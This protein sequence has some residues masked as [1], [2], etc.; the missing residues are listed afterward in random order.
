MA[1]TVHQV[2]LAQTQGG[3][4]SEGSLYARAVRHALA[5]PPGVERLPKDMGNTL[6]EE[7]KVSQNHPIL[8]W[9]Y[10]AEQFEEG[11]MLRLK[12]RKISRRSP[13]FIPSKIIRTVG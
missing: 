4:V 3:G 1:L 13:E 7:L 10:V 6:A 5:L 9:R 12:T 2:M 8:L 11:H